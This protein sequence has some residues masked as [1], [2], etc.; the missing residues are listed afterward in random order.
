[1]LKQKK[2]KQIVIIVMT[3]K[4]HHKIAL[5]ANQVIVMKSAHQEDIKIDVT[6]ASQ[7]MKESV[8]ARSFLRHGVYPPIGGGKTA[9]TIQMNIYL[10]EGVSLS[11]EIVAKP[12]T[13]ATR[14]ATQLNF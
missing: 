12:L 2:I 4:R 1:M 13:V 11:L 5:F 3:K 9:R 10:E 7:E 8:Y 14:L 6:I